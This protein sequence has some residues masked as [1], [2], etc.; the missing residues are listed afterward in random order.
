LGGLRFGFRCRKNP[1]PEKCY[2]KPQTPK[3]P[4]H[5]LLGNLTERQTQL[6]QKDNTAN[7]INFYTQPN[8]WQ[9]PKRT[10]LTK[11]LADQKPLPFENM[12]LLIE[13]DL[14]NQTEPN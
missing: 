6:P 11:T 4:L 13:T 9:L 1:K 8:F 14:T 12:T 3:N 10:Q 5:A 7:L 2:S